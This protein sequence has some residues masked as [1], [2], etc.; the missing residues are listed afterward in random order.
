MKRRTSKDQQKLPEELDRA[1]MDG[2][3]ANA[4]GYC[5]WVMYLEVTEHTEDIVQG[6]SE[7]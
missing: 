6:V 4:A 7:M 2:T 3:S 5:T 1:R